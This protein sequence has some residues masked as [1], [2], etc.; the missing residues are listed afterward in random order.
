MPD[1]GVSIENWALGWRWLWRAHYHVTVNKL[2][3]ITD[4]ETDR[5]RGPSQRLKNSA[6]SIAR[7]LGHSPGF[8]LFAVVYH[9][10]AE[11]AFCYGLD[12]VVF[13]TS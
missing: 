9:I 6:S 10:S 12:G 5:Y 11:S 4:V 1:C 2:L 3:D 13:G 8:A 7:L